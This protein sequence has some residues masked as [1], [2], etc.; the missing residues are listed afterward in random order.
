MCPQ[1]FVKKSALKRGLTL[2]WSDLIFS[3][4]V[5]RKVRQTTLIEKLDKIESILEFSQH[6]NSKNQ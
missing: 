5:R 4:F 1:S 3:V 6:W 2:K